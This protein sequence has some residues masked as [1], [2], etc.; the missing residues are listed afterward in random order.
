MSMV[1]ERR[2]F[3][4]KLLGG[5]SLL[6][7]SLPARYL[8]AACP[9]EMPLVDNAN[10]SPSIESGQTYDVTTSGSYALNRVSIQEGGTLRILA[11]TTLSIAELHQE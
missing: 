8:L 5:V 1:P 7:L 10:S 4:L 6:G 9:S 2:V 11:E 3:F